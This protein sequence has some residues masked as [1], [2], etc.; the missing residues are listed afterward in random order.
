[1]KT[2]IKKE[3]E[4]YKPNHL[5]N[6]SENDLY[7]YLI[8]KYSLD[9][10]KINKDAIYVYSSDEVDIDVSQDP[11]RI[12]FD[13]SKPFYIKG[14]QIIITVSFSGDKRLF[15]YQPSTFSL[16]P[17]RAEVKESEIHLIY[18]LTEHNPEMLKQEYQKD[19]E[20][21]EK[22]LEWI[23]K[24]TDQFNKDLEGYIRQLIT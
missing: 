7:E 2:E 13:R 12:I 23:F 16:N 4:S 20:E 22:Y 1:M 6:V 24:E 11:N 19:L 15:H 17:S 10:S 9:V 14:T 3:I 21:I 18:E 8:S 5:L